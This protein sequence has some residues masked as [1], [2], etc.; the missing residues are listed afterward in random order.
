M[1]KNYFITLLLT[2]FFT[3]FSTGQI[4]I[5]EIADPDNDALA[6]Y[7]EIYNVS[8][9]SVDLTGWAVKRWTNGNAS[10]TESS[11]IDLSSIGNLAAGAFVVIAAD[12]TNFQAVYGMAADIDAGADGPADSNGDDQMA[13][14]DS[15][16]NIIDIFGVPGEDGTGTC[17]E[18]EN[19][20]AERKAS[21]TAS[22]P[23]WDE[24]EWNV[25]ADSTAN[26][27]TNHTNSPRTAPGDF[28]P[29]ADRHFFIT[30]INYR[31]SVRWVYHTRNDLCKYF[32]Y[33][34]KLCCS[35]SIRR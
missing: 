2:F 8:N 33:S 31:F 29:G 17:H 10:V 5:T 4:I 27:C 25:W 35:S 22:N 28:D 15:G 34:Y 21:V 13:I 26:G 1:K 14:F 7:I 18:F 11:A 30:D 19:G 16:N 6:R 23:T 32:H 12:G 9:G 3:A 20:R 24:S